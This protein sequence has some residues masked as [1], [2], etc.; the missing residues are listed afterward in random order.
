[1]NPSPYSLKDYD[2]SR[3]SQHDIALVR[4][5]RRLTVSRGEVAPICILGGGPGLSSKQAARGEL[6][7][8]MAGWGGG[9]G[10]GGGTAKD[11]AQDTNSGMRY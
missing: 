4:L 6:V 1:M 10:G 11:S 8:Y 2:P 5:G 7:V 3:P 9:G